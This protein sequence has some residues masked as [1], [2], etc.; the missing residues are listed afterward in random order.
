[1]FDRNL[2][3]KLLSCGNC[4]RVEEVETHVTSPVVESAGEVA[5][6]ARRTERF[7]VGRTPW[8]FQPDLAQNILW[9]PAALLVLSGMRLD[10]ADSALFAVNII[11]AIA[12]TGPSAPSLNTVLLPPPDAPPSSATDPLVRRYQR[13]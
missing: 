6:P 1:M 8:E 12:G 13:D 7:V 5:R 2:H 9:W 10:E 3:F 11:V 4:V